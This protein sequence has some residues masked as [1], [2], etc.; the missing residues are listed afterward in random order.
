M[1]AYFN[2]Y[3]NSKL[4]QNK[5]VIVVFLD[6]KKAFDTLSHIKIIESLENEVGVTLETKNWFVDFLRSRSA[7]VKINETLSNKFQLNS[8]VPQGSNLGPLL[9]LAQVISMAKLPLKTKLFQYADDT[10][11]IAAHK[12]FYEAENML[13]ND[14]HLIQQWVH[15]NCLILN[16]NKTTVM[17]VR[18]PTKPSQAVKIHFHSDACLHA[19][20]IGNICNCKEI[21]IQ[22]QNQKYL[23]VMIDDAFCWEPH[24]DSV[25]KRL[26]SCAFGLS[27]LKNCVCKK[28]LIMVYQALAESV[29]RYGLT[30]WGSGSSTYLFRIEKLQLA[31]LK[32]IHKK[33][34]NRT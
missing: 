22:V 16:K 11:L 31:L 19:T 24:M 7:M 5:H 8:G 1:L 6:L 29:V 13:R 12:D 18:P 26:R 4:N 21:L 32:I 20:K 27:I 3:I 14:L 9:Y 2:N 23:G 10:V 30:A 25:C 15:D 28:T 33:Q 34:N 17:H